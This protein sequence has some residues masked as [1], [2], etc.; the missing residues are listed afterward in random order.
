MA[1]VFIV[2]GEEQDSG[3]TII[4]AYTTEAEAIKHKNNITWGDLGAECGWLHV[5]E[6]NVKKKYKKYKQQELIPN[7][8]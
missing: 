2:Y 7:A 1:Q 3:A 5:A 8:N 4:A 6:L